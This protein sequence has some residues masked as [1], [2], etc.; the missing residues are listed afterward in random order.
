MKEQ[1]AKHSSEPR[2]NSK[3]VNCSEVNDLMEAVLRSD[4]LLVYRL[5][6]IFVHTAPV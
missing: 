4:L 6:V 1:Q 5:A 2:A 3:V